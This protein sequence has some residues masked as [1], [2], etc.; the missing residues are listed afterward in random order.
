M[1]YGSPC[2]D[3]SPPGRR[4]SRLE[5]LLD[6]W[7]GPPVTASTATVRS[8][9][10]DVAQVASLP[11]AIAEAF[12]INI[13]S[14]RVTRQQAMAIPAVKRGRQVIAG[15]IGTAPLVATRRIAGRAPERVARQLLTQ[16]SPNVTRAWV[17][18]WTVDALL[19]YGVAWWRVT[20][21]E[22]GVA[23]ALGY[24]RQVEWVAPWR[25]SIAPGTEERPEGAVL[26]DGR[27]V[28]DRDLIR[29]DGPDE[30]V[31]WSCARS[32]L[33]YAALEDGVRKFA[34]LDVPLGW[35]E[36]QEGALDPD[37]SLKML[38]S[39]ETARAARTTGYVPRGLKYQPNTATPAALQLVE[40]RGFQAAEIARGMNLPNSYVNAPSGDSLT[41]ATTESN[42]RELV[43]ITLAPYVS[44]IEQR[45]SMPDVTPAGT[46]VS[47]DLGKF[48]R[49]DIRSVLEAA[50][51]GIDAG[52]L[53]PD[54]VR[55]Q[56]LDLPP[57]DQP[58]KATDPPTTPEDSQP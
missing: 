27:E 16:P 9:G 56:W 35:F 55:D 53:D 51:I 31:L 17:L 24:P 37:E 57:M 28:P 33:T 26:V 15:T 47:L 14:E 10:G 8:W 43:D 46:T 34:R 20:D 45:L 30:G 38:G 49:G 44:A 2:E 50:K 18:T 40:A 3:R 6:R 48:I 36:D 1:V 32:I 58:S 25:V 7:W 5:R 54:W 52:V 11:S 42:R 4:V 29:F 12:G 39:W 13:S 19:F 22:P 21:R 23:G 41:Y